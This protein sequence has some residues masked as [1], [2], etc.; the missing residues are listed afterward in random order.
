METWL[1]TR[2]ME[3]GSSWPTLVAIAVMFHRLRMD[4]AALMT[5]VAVI[6]SKLEG[7]GD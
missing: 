5:R 6:E 4:H 1:G 7:A 2:L 3:I